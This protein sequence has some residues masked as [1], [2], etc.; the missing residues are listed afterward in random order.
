MRRLL[1][2]RLVWA[3]LMAVWGALPAPAETVVLGL[4]QHEVAI[5]TDFRGSH[6]WVFG[7]VR[8]EA[9]IPA[10]D[11][12]A[13]IVT[14]AGPSLPVVVRRKERRYGIWLNVDKVHLTR[15]PSFYAVATTGPLGAILAPSEDMRYHI[16][17]GRQIGTVGG[18][19]GSGDVQ[20]YTDALERIRASES[21]YQSLEGT[22]ALDEQTLFS[23]SLALP[24]N[25]VEGTYRARIF[26]LR[27]TQVVDWAETGIEVRKV[28]LERWLF[29][30]AHQQPFR[31]GVMSL[32]IA[33]V[34]GWLASAAFRIFQR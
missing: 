31:Y 33:V 28:G 13:V 22:V 25:I 12:L 20:A 18:A 19:D 24:S 27:D 32:V 2:R 17:V 30:F 7:A 8:R 21:L 16:S 4:S 15:V 34:A 14:V 3:L 1:I 9:P 23:T 6:L 5:T 26:L 29:L 11:G 10:K